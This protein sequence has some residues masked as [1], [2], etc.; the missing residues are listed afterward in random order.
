M[1]SVLYF[2]L[3]FILFSF[4]FMFYYLFY[5]IFFFC[6]GVK[7]HLGQI[8]AQIE[9]HLIYFEARYQCP[10]AGHEIG[11]NQASRPGPMLAFFLLLPHHSTHI[12]CMHT[13]AHL[14]VP[15]SIFSYCTY[16]T[17]LFTSSHL[18]ANPCSLVTSSTPLDHAITPCQT[19]LKSIS[20]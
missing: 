13:K 6:V 17:S 9:A 15:S 12:P 2:I 7:A 20:L 14:H 5:F 18:Q 10:M 11:P 4:I 1:S 16:A 19:P 8:E 3:T